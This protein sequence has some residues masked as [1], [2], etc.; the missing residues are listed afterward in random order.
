MPAGFLE[1]SETLAAAAA[2]ETLEEA[3]AEVELLDLYTVV[4]V[5]HINQVHMFYLGNMLTGEFSPGVESLETAL[6][7][8]SEIPWGEIAFPT[9]YKTLQAYYED[10]RGGQFSMRVMNITHPIPKPAPAAVSAG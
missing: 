2:R 9:V 4:N 1:N 8:E 6:F 5:P 10:L 7:A 3:N